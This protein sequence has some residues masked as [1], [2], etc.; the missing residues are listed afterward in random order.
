MAKPV[1]K[2]M[3]QFVDYLAEHLGLVRVM[4]RLSR[5]DPHFVRWD[6]LMGE[7]WVSVINGNCPSPEQ[8]RAALEER[9]NVLNLLPR[10][11]VAVRDL[12]PRLHSLH[13][14]AVALGLPSGQAPTGWA[15][16]AEM[17]H[18][19]SVIKMLSAA[20]DD[21]KGLHALDRD[22]ACF[23]DL[24]DQLLE[25]ARWTRTSL[26]PSTEDRAKVHLGAYGVE[27]LD[28]ELAAALGRVCRS[29]H[30]F[31]ELYAEFPVLPP[32]VA[33]HLEPLRLGAKDDAK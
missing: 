15:M 28:K 17:L 13:A 14:Y 9:E 31:C 1:M 5:D 3:T 24:L 21:A 2:S 6:E 25:M 18:P 16:P 32:K 22:N 23:K 27:A 10:L 29:M 30:D 26:N 20:L 19:D 12:V 7:R 4:R 11:Q 8:R 33:I